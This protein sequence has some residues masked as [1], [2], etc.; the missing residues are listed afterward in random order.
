MLLGATRLPCLAILLRSV[1]TCCVSQN[2]LV[3]T[4]GAALLHEPVKHHATSTIWH[5]KLHHFLNSSQQH[6]TCRSTSQ[7]GGATCYAQQGYDRL[8]EAL[9]RVC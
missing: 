6:P 3:S 2:E 8:A 7:Q 9:C 4:P 1:A 5:E